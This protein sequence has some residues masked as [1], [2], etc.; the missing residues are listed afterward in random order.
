VKKKESQYFI[1]LSKCPKF[2][3]REG[4]Q[5]TALTGL[6]GEKMMM[7]LTATLPKSEVPTHSHPH[8]QIGMVYSGKA[9]LRIGNKE[10]VVSKGDFYRIP[11]NVPPQRCYH[12]RR[13][14]LE[15]ARNNIHWIV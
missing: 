3:P 4:V 11:S 13:T 9:L 8:E 1:D 12:R 10:R 15:S 14:F 2:A 6:H 5:T 7:V